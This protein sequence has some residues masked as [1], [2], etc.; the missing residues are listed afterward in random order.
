MKQYVVFYT[1]TS[2]RRRSIPIDAETSWLAFG[3]AI[4]SLPPIARDV[5]IRSRRPAEKGVAR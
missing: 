2:G 1:D 3:R 4:R 5:L